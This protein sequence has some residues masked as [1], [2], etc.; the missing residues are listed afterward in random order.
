[1]TPNEFEA[2]CLTCPP[3]RDVTGTLRMLGFD[4]TFQM[5]ARIYPASSAT[6]PLPAQYHYR[7]ARGTEVIYLAGH[8]ADLDGRHFPPHQS[9]FWLYPGSDPLAAGRAMR[10]LAHTWSFTWC[11][12][13][14]DTSRQQS[15]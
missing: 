3:E 15:A 7:D 14:T 1:M 6:P 5:P 12:P 8:D 2:F 10:L 9:R 11:S 13:H 4:L